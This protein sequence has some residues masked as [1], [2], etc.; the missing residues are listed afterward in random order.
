MKVVLIAALFAIT[1]LSAYFDAKGF[2]YAAQSWR[3]G[4]I[5]ATTSLLSLINF[6]GGV[7]LY[8]LSIGFQ[9][10]LGVQSAAMQSMFWFA[11]TVVG[12]AILD[13]TITD[14]S[15]AQRT[16]GAVVTVGIGWL[17]VSTAH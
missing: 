10:R 2:V 12:I 3:S 16:V 9:Q 4:S 14:W 11:M 13:S 15:I 17:L 8:I 7:T 6:I 1:A 5:V